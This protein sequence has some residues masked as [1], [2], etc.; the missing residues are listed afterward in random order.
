MTRRAWTWVAALAPADVLAW[1]L[2]LHAQASFHAPP[3]GPVTSLGIVLGWLTSIVFLIAIG[4]ILL[5][6]RQA[7]RYQRRA[8]GA[9]AKP[10]SGPASGS[11]AAP[12]ATGAAGG[13][14]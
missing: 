2:T 5:A 7:T 11:A 3:G 10:A 12:P 6:G 8:G 1:V 9:D 13:A 14:A 4:L